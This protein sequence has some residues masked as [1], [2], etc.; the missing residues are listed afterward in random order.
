MVESSLGK[1]EVPGY[2]YVSDLMTHYNHDVL[3]LEGVIF[4]Q[5]ILM[6]TREKLEI[7]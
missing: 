3:S 6:T 2:I 4:C 5:L 7:K 1:V